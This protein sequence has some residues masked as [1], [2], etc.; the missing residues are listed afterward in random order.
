ML[1][2][3]HDRRQPHRKNVSDMKLKYLIDGCP[4]VACFTQV[5]RGSCD[6]S[7]GIHV[8]RIANFPAHVVAEAERLAVALEK[9]EHLHFPAPEGNVRQ[10]TAEGGRPEC[11]R[12]L[13]IEDIE[14]TVDDEGNG[15]GVG[16]ATAVKRSR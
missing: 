2:I 13:S 1:A 6:R 3:C 10:A 11:K 14:D 7:F 12:K 16:G 9:G 4:F 15:D 8:A 5:T